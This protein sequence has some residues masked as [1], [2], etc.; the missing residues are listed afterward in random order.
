VILGRSLER[1]ALEL[2]YFEAYWASLLPNGEAFTPRAAQFSTTSW[3]GVVQ[4]FCQWDDAV[5]FAL[6][7][8][9]LE[10][11]GQHSGQHE[12][13]TEG[14]RMY[15]R[16]LHMLAKLLPAR[17]PGGSDKLLAASGLLAAYEVYMNICPYKCE[18]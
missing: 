5:R 3:I 9:A 4:D 14:W 10:L 13:I 17:T 12:M 6:L 11:L 18:H 7:S 1:T 15:G 2:K 8:N 16:S